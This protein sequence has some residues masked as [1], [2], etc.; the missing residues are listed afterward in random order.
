[1]KAKDITTIG[2]MQDFI[3]GCVNDFSNGISSK[4]DMLKALKEYTFRVLEM[5]ITSFDDLVTASHA[6]I[7]K[8]GKINGKTYDFQFVEKMGEELME[9]KAALAVNKKELFI[10]EVVDLA[11][12]CMVFLE[13]RGVK[14]TDEYKKCIEWNE[15]RND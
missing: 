7:V 14:F 11:N 6:A 12:V 5:K 2:E 1:M 4:S 15:T 13:H 9:V 8:R 10:R 3:E